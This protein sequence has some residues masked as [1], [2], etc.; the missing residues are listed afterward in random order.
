MPGTNT[1]L[2]DRILYWLRC[3]EQGKPMTMPLGVRRED[4]TIYPL[5]TEDYAKLAAVRLAGIRKYT[6]YVVEE[7]EISPDKLESIREAWE[8][9]HAQGN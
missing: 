7:K 9:R 8:Q 4:G 2:L 6:M 3:I 1:I 5:C